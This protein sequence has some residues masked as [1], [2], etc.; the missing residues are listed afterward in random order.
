MKVLRWVATLFRS[1][2]HLKCVAW[3]LGLKP[4]Y[5]ASV[6]NTWQHNL[7]LFAWLLS[8]N[9]LK[10]TKYIFCH[11]FNDSSWGLSWTFLHFYKD[12]WSF[13]RTPRSAEGLNTEIQITWQKSW[14]SSVLY[15]KQQSTQGSY[16]PV[17]IAADLEDSSHA[18]DDLIGNTSPVVLNFAWSHWPG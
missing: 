10:H 9:L 4:S 6:N 7:C 12:L 5:F 16:R 3:G 2:T 11:I 15:I 18:V 1:F 14:F 8:L 13:H 17:D